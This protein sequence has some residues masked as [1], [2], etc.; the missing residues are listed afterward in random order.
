MH[1]SIRKK[2]ASVV[3]EI[4]FLFN[5]KLSRLDLSAVLRVK[6]G[7]QFSSSEL[8]ISLCVCST[9]MYYIL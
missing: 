8:F 1:S 4:A 7:Q 6:V 2:I 9:S 3:G 5:I